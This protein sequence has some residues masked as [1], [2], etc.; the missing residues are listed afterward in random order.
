[1]SSK[2]TRKKG[3]S[4]RA[5]SV[6]CAQCGALVPRDKAIAKRRHGLPLN[7]RLIKILKDQ[8]ARIHSGKNTVYY[9]VSCAKHRK[10]V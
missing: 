4:G 5:K 7:R 1:M 3:Q 10:Y 9:C 6:E 8:G 2:I